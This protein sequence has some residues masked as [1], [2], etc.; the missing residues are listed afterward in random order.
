[1]MRPCI[2]VLLLA[3]A[4]GVAGCR[5]GGQA[6]TEL[7]ATETQQS[8]AA[9]LEEF[10]RIETERQ[11]EQLRRAREARRA[12]LAERRREIDAASA[13]LAA[14]ERRIKA[15]EA[16]L[17]RLAEKALPWA[18]EALEELNAIPELEGSGEEK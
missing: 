12:L 18:E 4:I 7:P 13:E 15:A 1:M 17:E 10:R 6:R 9:A 16:E 8:D 2:G 11:Q 14:I 3:A 5:G